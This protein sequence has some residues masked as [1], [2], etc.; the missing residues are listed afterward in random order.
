VLEL[1]TFQ[2]EIPSTRRLSVVP[3]T[4]F[5]GKSA[6]EIS[7]AVILAVVV[8]DLTILTLR[9]IYTFPV[10]RIG[11]GLLPADLARGMGL[12]SALIDLTALLKDAIFVELSEA[13]F[14][15]GLLTYLEFYRG[16]LLTFE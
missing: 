10:L 3:A 2:A 8:D 6:F 15:L 14:L 12:T 13:C 9:V 1:V 4:V 5:P 16:R 11:L 7:E